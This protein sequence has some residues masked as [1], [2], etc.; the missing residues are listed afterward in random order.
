VVDKDYIHVI[1]HREI[2]VL[3]ILLAETAQKWGCQPAQIVV[4]QCQVCHLEQADAQLIGA[5]REISLHETSFFQC[6]QQTVHG[7]L[8][9]PDLIGDLGHR[10]FWRLTGEA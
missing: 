5:G 10:E 8:V 1:Q 4:L 7:A 2:H 6:A 3:L 9:D